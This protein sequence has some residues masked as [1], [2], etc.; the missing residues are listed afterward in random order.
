M[1]A[2]GRPHPIPL[3]NIPKAVIPHVPAIRFHKSGD[4]L[5]THSVS[6]ILTPGQRAN[7]RASQGGISVT[8]AV[9]RF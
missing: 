2:V 7:M 9:G 3:P 1:D 6:F 5:S 4:L 8:S